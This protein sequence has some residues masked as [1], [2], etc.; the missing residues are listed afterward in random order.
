MTNNMFQRALMFRLETDEALIV[1][2]TLSRQFQYYE[3]KCKAE[4]EVLNAR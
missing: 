2:S 3:I 4:V 1:F